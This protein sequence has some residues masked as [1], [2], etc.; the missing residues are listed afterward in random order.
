MGNTGAGRGLHPD[1]SNVVARAVPAADHCRWE[2]QQGLDINAG[3]G[4]GVPSKGG[5]YGPTVLLHY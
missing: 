2:G 5:P 3:W 4:W 1:P